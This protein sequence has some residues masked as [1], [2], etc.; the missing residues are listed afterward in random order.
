[1][2]EIKTPPGK[3][4]V[5]ATMQRPPA[6]RR[7]FMFD[8]VRHAA[9]IGVV[10]ALGT[11]IGARAVGQ[12][13]EGPVGGVAAP[14]KT[15]AEVGDAIERGYDSAKGR[16]LYTTHCSACHSADGEGQPG[17]FPPLKGSGVVT[18]DD[19]GKHIRVVLDGLQGAKAGGVIYASPMPPFA[20]ILTDAE[21]AA[22][23]DYE[24][25]SWGNHGKLVTADQV[26]AERLR[27]R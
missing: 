9:A 10:L 20:G 8:N 3:N 22:I 23:I 6:E 24:R 4:I 27:S 1:M 25:R 11:S 26:A 16:R 7:I 2:T 12:M 21:I 14:D 5:A 17:T 19:A 13:H 15:A 18:K